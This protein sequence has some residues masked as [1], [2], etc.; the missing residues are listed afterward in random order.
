MQSLKF[1]GER[2]L[3]VIALADVIGQIEKVQLLAFG[4]NFRDILQRPFTDP[5]PNPIASLLSP[6]KRSIKVLFLIDD[7]SNDVDTFE[8]FVEFPF[9]SGKLGN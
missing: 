3:Q 6:I 1:D 2:F 7:V 5:F 8:R 4:G 9:H